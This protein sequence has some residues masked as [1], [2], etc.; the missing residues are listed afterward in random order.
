M[1]EEVVQRLGS[2]G[3]DLRTA[4]DTSQC[5]GRVPLP[6]HD[7]D[8]LKRRHQF[9]IVRRQ[10]GPWVDPG[11]CYHMTIWAPELTDAAMLGDFRVPARLVQLDSDEQQFVLASPVVC[12]RRRLSLTPP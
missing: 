1:G 6:P 7:F 2:G 9:E 11:P 8:E 3:C 10:I 4:G 5:A 12:R